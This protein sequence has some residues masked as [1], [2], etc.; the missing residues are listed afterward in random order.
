[1][2]IQHLK[3]TTTN[4][5]TRSMPI[6][7]RWGNEQHQFVLMTFSGEWSWAELHAREQRELAAILTGCAP[8]ILM[9]MR[10]SIWRTTTGLNHQIAESGRIH[11]QAGVPAVIFALHDTG[12]G[13]LL[14]NFY[15]RYG[16]PRTYYAHEPD[17]EN[18]LRVV[19][20]APGSL[21]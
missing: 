15:R 1:L 21:S 16:S 11:G 14:V 6:T 20:S 18:A 4:T 9:D 8:P 17:F 7:V 19:R 10:G 2:I 13:T 3:Q 5:E 12:I